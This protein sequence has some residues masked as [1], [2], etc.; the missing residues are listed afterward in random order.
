M[1]RMQ[2]QDLIL[3][4]ARKEGFVSIPKTAKKLGVSV[5]TIRRDINALCAD[6]LLRKVHGGAAPVKAPIRKD[7]P[8]AKRVLQNQQAKIAIC[9]AAARMIRDGDVVTMDSGATC[10]VLASC[11]RDVHNVSFVVNSIHIATT[12]VD[13][14]NAGEISGRVIILGGELSPQSL[15]T[16]S[17]VTLDEIDKYHFDIAIIS[18]SSLCADG[19]ANTTVAG[20]YIPHLMRRASSC[21]LIADSEKVGKNSVYKFAELS[22]FDRIFIDNQHPCPEDIHKALDGTGT[23]LSVVDCSTI[24]D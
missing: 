12:L 20:S 17:I 2:R 13:K 3:K 22:D 1:I 10:A 18:C 24:S 6:N 8:Y 7:A 23:V 14:I 11:I 21:I 9:T 5:E 19:V 15:G 16:Y 4:I